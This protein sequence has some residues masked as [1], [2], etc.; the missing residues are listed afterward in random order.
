[1]FLVAWLY[2]SDLI[3]GWML[4][5]EEGQKSGKGWCLYISQ[6]GAHSR[7]GVRYFIVYLP[8]AP[9]GPTLALWLI[10]AWQQWGILRLQS[11]QGDSP[12]P[13]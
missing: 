13:V 1:M 12:V 6:Q 4:L 9:R 2:G 5:E 10:S 11:C 7:E 8:Y 3:H